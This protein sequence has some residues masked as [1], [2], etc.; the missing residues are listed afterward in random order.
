MARLSH[1][2]RS[3]TIID[4][5]WL[6][7]TYVQVLDGLQHRR[8]DEVLHHR[9]EALLEARSEVLLPPFRDCRLPCGV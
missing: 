4:E 5:R 8:L 2:L 3:H 6:H 7:L 9:T 1:A